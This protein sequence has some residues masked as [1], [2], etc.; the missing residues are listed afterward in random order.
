MTLQIA[1]LII[2]TLV[3][4]QP[5]LA[6]TPMGRVSGQVVEAG[7]NTP[8]PDALVV[9]LLDGEYSTSPGA[10]PESV[11]D[12]NGRYRFDTLP[13]GRYRIAAQK[14]GFE[15]P[16]DPSKMEV[17]EVAAGQALEGLTVSLRRGG[18]IAGRVLDPLGQPLAE[19]G[20]TALLKRLKSNDQPVG[21][22]SS[23]TPLLMPFG[24]SQTNGLGEFRIS[25]LSPGEYVIV[26]EARSKFGRAVTSSSSTTTMISTYFPGTADVS[27][28]QAVTVQSGETL[29][30]LTIRLVN[31]PA[32]QVSGVIV[33]EAGAPVADA[34]VVLMDGR[35]ADSLFSLPMGPRGMSPSDASGRF[36]FGDVP[37]GSY[38]LRVDNGPGGGFFAF[39]DD[40]IIDASGTPRA[41]LSRPR[42]QEPGTIEV[43]VEN[44]NI[45]DLKIVVPRS[46]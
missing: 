39:G 27:A 13:A 35:G 12:R 17:F 5:P 20:V 14:E 36:T 38:T 45:T 41:G 18:V 25:G 40:F 21:L 46:Q 10:P 6:V 8:V 32:L 19:V 23:G 15:P 1:S 31:V 9:V 44:A 4:S 34:M 22:T 42:P 3:A 7:T 43:T 26:A 28:A 16:M 11:S 24:Q 29:S 37:A 33:D 30:E 2:G